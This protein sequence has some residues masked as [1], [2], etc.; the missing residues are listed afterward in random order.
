MGS[1][2]FFEKSVSSRFFITGNAGFIGKWLMKETNAFG[3]DAK[4]CDIRNYDL[5]KKKIISA[6]PTHLI[7]L[8][9]IANPEVCEKNPNLAWD[10]NV[11]G[12]ENILKICEEQGIKAT[13]MSTA[14]VYKEKNAPLNES[15][16]LK[17]SGSVYVNTKIECEKLAK[18]YGSTIIRAF[19]QEGPNRPAEYFTS[20]AILSCINNDSLKLWNPNQVREY[21]D[22]RDGAKGIHLISLKGKGIFNLSTGRGI[23]KLEYVKLVEKV[24][25]KKI[26]Y[27][28]EKNEN[29][30]VIVGDNS[31][32]RELGWVQDCLL[33]KT[34]FDQ[35]ET[36]KSQFI[37]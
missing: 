29:K 33:E 24:L 35:A 3:F 21:M 30:S 19:N 9:A 26:N 22:V 16:E 6:K 34:I 4:D 18:E 11:T 10:V 7:H 8:A 28:V 15:N 25:N 23:S 36:L 14:Q 32:L 27:S 5:L 31:R 1:Y 12:T 2:D 13:I 20:K 37:F 17:D